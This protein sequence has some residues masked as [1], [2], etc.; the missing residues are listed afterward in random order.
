MPVLLSLL[1]T[2]LQVGDFLD[3]APGTTKKKLLL[4]QTFCKTTSAQVIRQRLLKVRTY[5]YMSQ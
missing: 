4:D 3:T 5:V 1:H 2:F